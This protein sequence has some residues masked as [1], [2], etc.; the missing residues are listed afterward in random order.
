MAESMAEKAARLASPT[1]FSGAGGRPAPPPRAPQRLATVPSPTQAHQAPADP[2]MEQAMAQARAMAEQQPDSFA[3]AMSQLQ[4]FTGANAGQGIQMVPAQGGNPAY[5]QLPTKEE[6]EPPQAKPAP[7]PTPT[8]QAKQEAQP[9]PKPQGQVSSFDLE[10]LEMSEQLDV[11]ELMTNGYLF[12]E[13]EI[14]PGLLSVSVR[15]LKRSDKVQI[16]KDIDD[17][18]RGVPVDP[19]Q[20]DG[21]RVIP[22]PD[23]VAD[24]A[25][26]RQLSE[27][28]MGINGVPMV[29]DWM[30]R[31]AELEDRD[32]VQY[33]AIKRE[34]SKFLAAV[35][36]LFPDKPTKEVIEKLKERL[37]KARAH[38]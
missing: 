7:N 14:I 2:Q 31:A 22:F 35:G 15:S 12:R 24:F 6:P 3:Q 10:V 34:Y 18:R 29:N 37:G 17:F 9:E 25:T 21:P 23:A 32:D 38:L 4:G 13:L 19:A 30:Q 5:I 20:P 28:V 26:L 36:L 1:G 33:E 27:G 8:P 11:G 16:R